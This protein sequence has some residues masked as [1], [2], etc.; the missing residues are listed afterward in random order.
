MNIKPDSKLMS[1]IHLD[2]LTIVFFTALLAAIITLII[3]FAEPQKL[4]AG[5]PIIWGITLGLAV[6]GWIILLPIATLWVKNLTY[7]IED[8]RV[9]IHKGIITKIQQNIPYRAITD[10]QLHRSL[11]DRVLGIGSIRIQTA[12]Q[13]T[14]GTG[15]EGVLS[16]L[17]NYEDLHL[18]LRAKLTRLHPAADMATGVQSRTAPPE[19]D[20]SYQM[21]EELRAIRKSLE[22][23]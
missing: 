20:M 22:R 3:A 23:S 10:F 8:D 17:L 7:S 13:H 6:L 9:T 19:K 14:G 18:Q 2:Y 1:R 15:F 5:L 21:L 16:G 11:W 12:G 4:E